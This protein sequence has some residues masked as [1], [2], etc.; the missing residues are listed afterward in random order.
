LAQG[1]LAPLTYPTHPLSDFIA[2]MTPLGMD[3]DEEA[4]NELLADATR[5]RHQG[6]VKAALAMGAASALLLVGVAAGRLWQPHVSTSNLV[7]PLQFD[8]TEVVP[9]H[10]QC[11]KPSENCLASKCCKVS[12]YKCFRKNETYAFCNKT[13]TKG[14]CMTEIVTKP[15]QQSAESDSATNLF[16]FSFYTENT[17]TTK[18]ST[19]LDL[20]R[21]QYFLGASIFGCESYQV[22]SDVVTWISDPETRKFVTVKV[23]DTNNDFHKEKRKK[24]GTWIN[25]NMFIATWK[26]I[27]KEE[28]IKNKD[29]IVKVDADAVFL[30]ERLREK[31]RTQ[32][33]TDNGIYIENCKYVSYGY[34]G[35]LEIF[36][37][38]AATTYMANLEDCKKTLNYLGKEKAYGNEA[39]G[40]DLFAQKCMDK[41]GVDKVDIFDITTDGACPGDRPKGQEKNKKWKPDCGTTKTPAMHPFK[42]PGDYFECLKATQ[43]QEA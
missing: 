3:S 17:G 15:S 23:E 14:S 10:E 11:A 36:S 18:P 34:F 35:N 12:G 22:Y 8:E 1:T 42:K 29:W 28:G 37:A 26:V 21:T 30:P 40:E 33:V 16:C 4:R 32:Q 19:E 13:C 25:A 38:K 27:Q 39:W 5:P 20:L 7:T 2:T 43:A 6:W 41:H 31:L 9:A 24:T